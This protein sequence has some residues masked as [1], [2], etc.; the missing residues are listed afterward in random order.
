M[1]ILA[2]LRSSLFHPSKHV[3][4]SW[5]SG[6]RDPDSEGSK[7]QLQLSGLL[8]VQRELHVRLEAC[9]ALR[10]KRPVEPK[11]AGL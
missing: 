4:R 8:P 10:S 6:A 11:E 9:D 1:K 7:L 3:C 2:N 5:R